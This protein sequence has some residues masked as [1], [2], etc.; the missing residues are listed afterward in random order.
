MKNLKPQIE[1]KIIRVLGID[2]GLQNFGYAVVEHSEQ[3]NLICAGEVLTQKEDNRR[4]VKIFDSISDVISTYNPDYC[5]IERTFANP[6][7]LFSSIALGQA[8]GIVLLCFQLA[9]KPYSEIA[10][11]SIKKLI[12]G[13]GKVTKSEI[14]AY[15]DGLFS[16]SLTHNAA[17]AVAICL[18]ADVKKM[19]L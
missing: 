18:C 1:S 5:V 6:K 8:R 3:M 2:P 12:C 7:N 17:D 11:T 13:N 15:V 4:L 14:Q 16:V 9:N 10:P 19:G